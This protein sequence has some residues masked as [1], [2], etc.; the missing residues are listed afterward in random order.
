ML[1]SF[2]V[3][4]SLI[5]D[6]WFGYW[7]C[8]WLGCWCWDWFGYW[9]WDWFG[10]GARIGLDA[11]AGIGLDADAG[12]GLDA[13]P[14][15]GLDVGAGIGL[16]LLL[17]SLQ[18][19]GFGAQNHYFFLAIATQSLVNTFL[20]EQGIDVSLVSSFVLNLATIAS[21]QAAELFHSNCYPHH[22]SDSTPAKPPISALSHHL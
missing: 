2:T 22:S 4:E 20:R 14:G 5:G 18:K 8:K 1:F 21:M 6:F 11:G 9:C 3:P 10:F 19:D 16:V 12:I 13:G 7:C 15:T 17:P